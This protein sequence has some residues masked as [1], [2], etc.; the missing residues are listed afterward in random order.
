MRNNR[1]ILRIA[2]VTETFLPRV[3]GVTNTLRHVLAYFA[4]RGHDALMFAPKGAPAH[5]AGT[6]IIS[7]DGLP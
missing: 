5:F 7:F 2:L 3:D 6:R 4:K 1:F